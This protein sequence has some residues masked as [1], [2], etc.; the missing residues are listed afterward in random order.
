MLPVYQHGAFNLR[1][2]NENIVICLKLNSCKL[3]IL[4]DFFIEMPLIRVQHGIFGS[5][6][7]ICRKYRIADYIRAS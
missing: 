2:I 7:H 6:N 4:P 3:K 5:Y 1:Y